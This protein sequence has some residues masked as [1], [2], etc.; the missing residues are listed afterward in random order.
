MKEK[1]ERLRAVRDYSV[2]NVKLL[3]KVVDRLKKNGIK[4]YMANGHDEAVD[5][6]YRNLNGE[7]LVVK[8]KSNVT[9]EIKL[10]SALSSRGVSVIETDIGD[11]IAQLIDTPPSHPTGP[12]VHLS[13]KEIAE[14]LSGSIDIYKGADAE[15]IVNIMKEDISGYLKQAQIGITGANA[16]TAEE[17]SIILAH[18]E[19]NIYEVM[20]RRK[21]IV[22]TGMDK[23]Y[24]T[25]EDAINMLKVLSYNA[26]G[27]IITSFVEVISSVSRTADVEKQFIKGIHNPSEIVTIIIDNGRSEII[28]SLHKEILYCI[29][30]GNCLIYCPVYNT[31]GMGFAEGKDLGGK[32]LALRAL[33]G[34][35]VNERLQ[36]CLTCGKCKE[37]CP[38]RID[39]P[40]IIR[41]LRSDQLAKE[42]YYFLKSHLLW[43]Y[44]SFRLRFRV[45]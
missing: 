35:E 6:I 24:P 11:R 29:D 30:C 32:G 8:S 41:D 5:L 2:G 40:Q 4:V 38:V 16:L 17:G 13:A 22:V 25:I 42:I 45:D 27:S 34:E 19:G 39:I 20:K 14:G 10:P 21:H 23:I 31:I 26:T 33:K 15:E 44:Y 12:V 43:L 9:K 7:R 28:N 36:F 18:N 1:Q 37:H 3:N